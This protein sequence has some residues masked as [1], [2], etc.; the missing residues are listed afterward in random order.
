MNA[1]LPLARRDQIAARLADGQPVVA[2]TL[3]REFGVSEDAI[4]RDLRAL[5]AEG[6][7]R[8]VYGGAL[9]CT[10]AFSPVSARAEQDGPL[11]QAL[12]RAAATL[13][14]PGELIFLDSGSTPLALVDALP[15]EFELT[16]ATHAIDIAAAVLRRPGMKLVM[17]GGCVDP[18][19]GGALDATTAQGL[20][21]LNIDRCFL[22]A[23]AVSAS[24]GLSAQ[25]AA[26]AAFKRLLLQASPHSTVLVT[27]DKFSARAPH[28]IAPA[29]A[30][31]C[32]VLSPEAP[33][34]EA[35]ALQALGCSLLRA[36][37]T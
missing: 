17:L 4:R 24:R 12:A 8:R 36:A 23:C 6:R 30:V 26:D 2:A 1:D 5:A 22:G 3:A 31:Q 33:A 25:H 19:V 34:A 18:V 21:Q 35:D 32:F 14:Q 37:A 29:E 27:A 7:C 28:R 13:V 11:K 10:P 9:P 15:D 20:A 16:V